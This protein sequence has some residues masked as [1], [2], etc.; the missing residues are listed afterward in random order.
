MYEHYYEYVRVDS[1]SGEC[2]HSECQPGGGICTDSVREC[3]PGASCGP[4]TDAA[5]SPATDSMSALCQ[6]GSELCQR[7]VS[8]GCASAGG[9]R[10]ENRKTYADNVQEVGRERSGKGPERDRLRTRG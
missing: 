10:A 6:C 5:I 3:A 4:S 7:A 9:M 8:V 2:A 1:A